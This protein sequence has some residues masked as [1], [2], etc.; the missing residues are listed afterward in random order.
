MRRPARLVAG[1]AVT[2]AAGVAFLAGR[3][4]DPGPAAVASTSPADG[5]TLA[6]AP[7]DVE[8][9]F[10][11]RVDPGRS[12]LSVL[13]SARAAG[14]LRQTAP[15]R[16]SQP[17]AAQAGG[18]VTVAYHVTLTDGA[19]LAGSLRFTVGAA[20]AGKTSDPAPAHAHGIDPVSAVLLVADGVAVLAV[21]VL[22]MRRP[23]P[24]GGR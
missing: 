4:A 1:V 21:G 11:G 10:T 15:E 5:A 9:S 8:L 16:L 22:L 18:E 23:R 24:R 6:G 14:A 17:I 2:L 3:P 19:E 13:G 12:H 20:G 7:D